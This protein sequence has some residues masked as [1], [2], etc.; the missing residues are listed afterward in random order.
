MPRAVNLAS[1][2]SAIDAHGALLLY[3]IENRS[4][5]LS[6]WH[7]Y[8]P[9]SAMRWDWDS[10]G[11]DRVVA[12]WRLRERLAR[13]R[14]VVYAKWYRGRAT[15]FSRALFTAM[16]STYHAHAHGD[17][18]GGLDPDAIDVLDALESD[19]PRSTKELR[20]AVGLRGRVFEGAYQRALG[21]L[22]SRL[23]IVGVGE[24]DDGAFPSLAIGAS[25]TLFEDLWD[26]ALAMDP[27]R[28]ARVVGASLPPGS[29]LARQQAKTLAALGAVRVRA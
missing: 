19:S 11:D 13:S 25:R 1:A 9:R 23:L 28:A 20:A 15:F 14:R 18:R 26:E 22:W 4:E 24:V 5:P 21:A 29:M 27:S 8:H 7:H 10:T 3:P 2:V 12:L 16:L 6:L 17:L